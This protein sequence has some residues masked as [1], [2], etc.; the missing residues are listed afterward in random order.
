MGRTIAGLI[1]SLQRD[2]WRDTVGF[3]PDIS[4]VHDQIF[5]ETAT[6]DEIVAA[7]AGWL[8]RWQPCLFGRIAAKLGLITFCILTEEDLSESDEHIHEK[9][10][11]ARLDW[12]HEAYRGR[13]SAFIV[14][15]LS[16]G[17]AFAEPNETLASLAER[18]CYLYLEESIAFDTIHLD[19]LFLEN[20]D[21]SQHTWRFF[22]GVNYFS[23]QADKRW[24]NDHRIPGGIAFSVNS[25][26]HLVKSGQIANNL[27]DIKREFGRSDDDEWIGSSVDSLEDALIM[28]MRTISLASETASGKATE[29]KE[30][31]ESDMDLPKCPVALPPGLADKNHCEY[32]GRYHTDHSLPSIY[33]DPS[34]DRP[35]DQPSFSLDFTYLFHEDLENPAHVTMG[36]G[37]RIRDVG[38]ANAQNEGDGAST[39]ARKGEAEL[40]SIE[41]FKQRIS[42]G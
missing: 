27:A 7:L 23:P 11:S 21:G 35:E 6:N 22:T 37:K 2:S 17:I 36:Q 5:K 20:P 25:V 42:R 10:Q 31:A 41:L 24:W 4:E 28:A 33:F 16:S 40:V 34:V 15:A 32:T 3:S 9:I 14:V 26:A 29:L 30:L 38:D 39:G 13:K 1:G 18:L 19:Q 8:K 12:T